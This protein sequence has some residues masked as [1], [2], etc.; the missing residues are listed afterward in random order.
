MQGMQCWFCA[1]Y[2]GDLAC[3]AFPVKI[4]QE[5]LDGRFNHQDPYPDAAHPFD[6]GIRFV[7]SP[8][9]EEIV[10]RRRVEG[11]APPEER[12]G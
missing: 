8:R 12:V 4:P 5:I 7:M 1:H 3:T 6:W 11:K 9:I 2:L 10:Q